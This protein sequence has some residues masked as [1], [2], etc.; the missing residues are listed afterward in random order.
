MHPVTHIIAMKRNSL[1]CAALALV[2]SAGPGLCADE[3]PDP[4]IAGL[5]K[6]ATDFVTAYNDRKAGAIAALFTE[7]GEM[8]DLIGTD[9]TSGRAAIQARYEEIFAGAGVPSMAVEVASVRLVAPNLAI[10]DGTVHLTPADEDAPPVSTTYTATLLKN[11]AGVWQIAS[12]RE[13]QD[14]TGAAGQLSDLA[15]VLKGEWTCR[16][17]KGLQLD[18]AFGW[19]ASGKFLTGEMLTTIPDG[20]PQPGSMRI[21]WN[22]ARKTIV[23]WM[24][25]GDGGMM[26]SVW[27]PSGEGWLIRSEGTTADGET[28]TANQELTR[29]DNNTLLWSVTNRVIDGEKQPDNVIRI[30]RQ[31]P[32]PAAASN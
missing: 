3:Q 26:Q 16:N 7:D 27:T 12:T 6:S 23:S 30:V 17:Q 4:S 1:H 14:V 2:L 5:Q 13:L 24:F 9:T 31:A 21:G 15:R 11:E 18:L 8:T 32:Q 29:E 28:V 22:A 19:D 10:E 20:E 25:D